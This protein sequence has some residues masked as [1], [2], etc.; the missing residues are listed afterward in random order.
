MRYPSSGKLG[1]LSKIPSYPKLIR[2]QQNSLMESLRPPLKPCPVCK[3]AMQAS[4]SDERLPVYDTFTCNNCGTVVI[5][6]PTMWDQRPN[7]DD[8]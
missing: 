3:V 2:W 4:K 6:A 5:S 8:E 7:G 1:R